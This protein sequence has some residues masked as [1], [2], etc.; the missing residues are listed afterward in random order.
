V[1]GF[2]GFLLNKEGDILESDYDIDGDAS[3]STNEKK[4]FKRR[5]EGN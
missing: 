1:K 5:K 4:E 2:K 3:K